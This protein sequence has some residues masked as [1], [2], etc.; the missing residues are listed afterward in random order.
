[1]L[2]G[3][4]PNMPP[5]MPQQLPPRPPTTLEQVLMDDDDKGKVS[6]W[7]IG[8]SSLSVLEQV[9][10]IEPFPGAPSPFSR[11][12]GGRNECRAHPFNK[13][14]GLRPS[15]PPPPSALFPRLRLVP[16]DFFFHSPR[17]AGLETRRGLS[18]KLN[19]SARQVQVWFQNKRQRERKLS[20]AKGL[21][22][23]PGLPDT[24]A[25]AAAHA[26]LAA[27]GAT[28]PSKPGEGGLPLPPGT[29]APVDPAAAASSSAAATSTT[30]GGEGAAAAGGPPPPPHPPMKIAGIPIMRSTSLEGTASGINFMRS[31]SLEGTAL[32]RSL[33]FGNP[34]SFDDIDIPLGLSNPPTAPPQ[35]PPVPPPPQRPPAPGAPR[36]AAGGAPATGQ[37]PSNSA[38]N[39]T[40][41]GLGLGGGAG[42]AGGAGGLGGLKPPPG[43]GTMGAGLPGAGGLGGLGAPGGQPNLG[44]ANAWL[45]N[46]PNLAAMQAAMQPP[47]SADQANEATRVAVQKT[48][49][50]LNSGALNAGQAGAAGGLPGSGLP[51]GLP[52]GLGA[53]LGLGPLPLLLS[54]FMPGQPGGPKPPGGPGG[55]GPPGGM[56]PGGLASMFGNNMFGAGGPLGTDS[57]SLA[58]SLNA[59][60]GG[61]GDDP[62]SA[63]D[64]T[65]LMED[66]PEELRNE[67]LS[68]LGN[69]GV[70]TVDHTPST[71]DVMDGSLPLGGGGGGSGGGGGGGGGGMPKS[72]VGKKHGSMHQAKKQRGGWGGGGGHLEGLPMQKSG[73]SNL[74]GDMNLDALAG[75]GGG[76]GGN[77][78]DHDQ[79]DSDEAA[80]MHSS[81]HAGSSQSGATTGKEE[82]GAASV[83]GLSQAEADRM[84]READ[85][86]VQVITAGEEP[87]QIVWASEAWLRLCEYT[88]PQVLGHTLE[89]IQ[90]PLTDAQAVSSLMNAI[91]RG[92]PIT[93]SMVNHTRT[94]KAFSHTLRVEPL[95]DSRGHVQCLQATS[96]NIDMNPSGSVPRQTTG[97]Q[98]LSRTNSSNLFEDATR[99][100]ESPGM[101]PR[102]SGIAEADGEGGGLRRND[103]M[104]SISGLLPR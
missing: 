66:L 81:S 94:G 27:S 72:G 98:P 30:P 16:A 69:A 7:Q 56:P 6:R 17:F 5:G 36:N 74:L 52:G 101:S 45:A 49:E 68:S 104:M 2:P 38:A 87:F 44:N 54:S 47:L 77:I 100:G 70:P 46:L 37:P 13:R 28:V 18:R 55:R 34:T 67:L 103:S 78:F 12:V 48:R 53:G 60:G 14:R 3:Q 21:L 19:V 41:G 25:V 62:M 59:L 57:A 65:D 32:E 24:P 31:H 93:L 11:P 22:S 58:A 51:G 79:R 9:Y 86:Y 26:K 75:G 15:A 29:T 39:A 23:T 35:P 71:R 76:L 73:V 8:S 83:D 102:L 99:V 20:R 97:S 96:S 61:I 80:S 43:F 64:G 63:L 89:L 82:G 50:L 91:R 1:M 95:R 84:Q 42:G 40:L 90:G 88:S 4:Q 10:A 33:S 85:S 92:D